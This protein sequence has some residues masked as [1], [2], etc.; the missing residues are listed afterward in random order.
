MRALGAA[1]LDLL[2][3]PCCPACGEEPAPPSP[4]CSTCDGAIEPAPEADGVRAG[5]LFG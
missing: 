5:A 2:F 4:F 1:L 3:P